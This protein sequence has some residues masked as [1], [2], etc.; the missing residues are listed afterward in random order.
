MLLCTPGRAHEQAG[1]VGWAGTPPLAL[2]LALLQGDITLS[3]LSDT[4]PFGNWIVIKEVTG[5]LLVAALE[6]AVATVDATKP[7][8]AFAQASELPREGCMAL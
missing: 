8:G 4:F 7:G 3:E 2:W 5:P 1:A 6:N